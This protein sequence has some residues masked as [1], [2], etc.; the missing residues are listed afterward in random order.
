MEVVIAGASFSGQF[1][2]AG[3][4]K[5]LSAEDIAFIRKALHA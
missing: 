1:D 5:P 2:I 3:T 4:H